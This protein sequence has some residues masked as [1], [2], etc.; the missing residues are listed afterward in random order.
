MPLRNNVN[1]AET[2]RRVFTFLW[3]KQ[4]AWENVLT[5]HEFLLSIFWPRWTI[6][7]LNSGIILKYNSQFTQLYEEDIVVAKWSHIFLNHLDHTSWSSPHHLGGDDVED[8]LGGDDVVRGKRKRRGRTKRGDATSSP[9]LH[10]QEDGKCQGTASS[11]RT[12]N[13]ILYKAMPM[14]ATSSKLSPQM[15]TFIQTMVSYWGQDMESSHDP[16]LPS[17]T[18]GAVF[19]DIAGPPA[20][21]PS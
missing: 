9:T 18:C 4:D 15:T 20:S 19:A 2:R 3:K 5:D 10:R 8:D 16:N 12:I 1:F 6:L 11:Q 14:I 17:W 21:L 7:K 13:S